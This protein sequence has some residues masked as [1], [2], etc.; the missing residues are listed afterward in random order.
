MLTEWQPIEVR[1]SGRP[2]VR[3]EGDVR[4]DME[5][6]KIQNWCKMAMDREVWEKT[7]DRAKTH[8]QL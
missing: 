6:M 1:R 7:G 3:W 8:E 5:K 4:A 2:I